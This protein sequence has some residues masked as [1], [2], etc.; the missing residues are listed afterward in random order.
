VAENYAYVADSDY[1]LLI[2][3]VSNPAAPTLKGS[4]D[5]AGSSEGVAVEGNY[6][7]VADGFNG[8]EIFR[9]VP[10]ISPQ[11]L[12]VTSPNGAENWTQGT[13]QTIR[14]NYTGDP[15]AYVKIELLKVEF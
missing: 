12:I 2:V 15:G 5:T 8:L 10:S 11:L 13:T 7:Y 3:D 1:G 14:W 6:A 4:Y 9:I